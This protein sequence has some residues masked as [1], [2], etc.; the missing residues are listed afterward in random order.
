MQRKR[1]EHEDKLNLEKDR[2]E[3]IAKQ[4]EDDRAWRKVREEQVMAGVVAEEEA[5][6]AATRAAAAE[7]AGRLA[8][9]SKSPPEGGKHVAE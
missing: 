8:T 9:A 7:H 2:R 5:A 4:M 6:A 1:K 3:V